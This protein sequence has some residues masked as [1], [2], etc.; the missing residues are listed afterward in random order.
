MDG[1]SFL[2]MLRDC[3]LLDANLTEKDADLLFSGK[4][5]AKGQRTIGFNS[6]ELAIQLVAEKKGISKD[7]VYNVLLESV[8]PVLQGTKAEANRFHDGLAATV[9]LN[10]TAKKAKS[11]AKLKMRLPTEAE[12]KDR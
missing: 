7:E 12:L 9:S 4:L 2:K 6:L 10:A 11:T 1:K 5:K 8:R 3:H